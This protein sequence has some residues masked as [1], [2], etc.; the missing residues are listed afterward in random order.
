[1]YVKYKFQAAHTVF[2]SKTSIKNYLIIIII[3][4]FTLAFVLH[5]SYNYCDATRLIDKRWSTSKKNIKIK[6]LQHLQCSPKRQ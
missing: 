6:C 4:Y 2:R 1:M 5:M 3:I